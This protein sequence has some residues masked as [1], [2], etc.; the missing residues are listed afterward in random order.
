MI[1]KYLIISNLFI[2]KYLIIDKLIDRDIKKGAFGTVLFAE[3]TK[4]NKIVALKLL[5]YG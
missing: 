2:I 5:N 1:F 4:T 3:H